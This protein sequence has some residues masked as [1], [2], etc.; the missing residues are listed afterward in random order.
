MPTYQ[1]SNKVDTLRT[2]VARRN[3]RI[4][5]GYR[6]A[7]NMPQEKFA[8]AMDRYAA[9]LR[10]LEALCDM[11]VLHYRLCLYPDGEKP[12]CDEPDFCRVCPKPPCQNCGGASWWYRKAEA[13]GEWICGRCHPRPEGSE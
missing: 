5:E 3:L 8:R 10:E 1:L 6:L 11:L 7:L 9:A 4:I 2:E 13:P 12:S